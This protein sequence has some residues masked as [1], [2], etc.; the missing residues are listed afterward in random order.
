MQIIIASLVVVV[1]TS[2]L[3]RILFVHEAREAEREGGTDTFNEKWKT[4]LSEG[5]TKTAADKRR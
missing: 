3:G 5:E 1:V 2:I 4:N